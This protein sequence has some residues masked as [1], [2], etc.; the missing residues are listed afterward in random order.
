MV[1]VGSV[2]GGIP[3]RVEDSAEGFGMETLVWLNPITQSLGLRMSLWIF[4]MPV[5]ECLNELF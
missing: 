4:N 5:T 3:R 2:V 1:N